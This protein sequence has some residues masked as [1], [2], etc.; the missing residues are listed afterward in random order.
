VAIWCVI[1]SGEYENGGARVVRGC[2]AG[3]S[4]CVFHGASHAFMAVPR[5]SDVIVVPCVGCVTAAGGEDYV[6]WVE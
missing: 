6:C 4:D 5:V 1:P 3:A 2:V